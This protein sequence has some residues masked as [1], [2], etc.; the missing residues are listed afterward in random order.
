M[1]E[2]PHFSDDS[3]CRIPGRPCFPTLPFRFINGVLVEIFRDYPN[4]LS[5]VELLVELFE[6]CLKR[7]N[8]AVAL[9]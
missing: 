9:G 7:R 8:M 5:F 4:W 1:M 3:V 6:L 2:S